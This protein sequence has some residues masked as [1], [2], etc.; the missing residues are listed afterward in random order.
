MRKKIIALAVAL[1]AALTTALISTLSGASSS[2][3]AEHVLAML[4][5][6]GHHLPEAFAHQKRIERRRELAG[7]E[8]GLPRHRGG[9]GRRVLGDGDGVQIDHAVDAVVLI[10]QRHPVAQ[11]PQVVADV[12]VPCGLDA[13]EDLLGWH[14]SSRTAAASLPPGRPARPPRRAL[15]P[16]QDRRR[17]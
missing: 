15:P 8:R 12:D 4:L 10:L 2:Q 17:G 14:L 6:L 3:M 7:R 11:R 1:T 16:G 9:E 5:A 13:R